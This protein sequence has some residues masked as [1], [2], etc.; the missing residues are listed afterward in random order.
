MNSGVGICPKCGSEDLDYG[1]IEVQDDMVYY[2]FTCSECGA[3]GKEWYDLDFIES[4]ID[5]EDEGDEE[6]EEEQD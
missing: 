6:R 2:P 4:T 1:V 3:E 5:D